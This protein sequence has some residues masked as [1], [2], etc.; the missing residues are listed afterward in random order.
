MLKIDTVFTPS[1]DWDLE[2]C[3]SRT[4]KWTRC[5]HEIAS[6]STLVWKPTT[7]SDLMSED[8]V[9]VCG[10]CF[11]DYIVMCG[12]EATSYGSSWSDI[13]HDK[14]DNLGTESDDATER[15]SEFTVCAR[16]F[17]VWTGD[18]PILEESLGITSYSES[19]FRRL[20]SRSTDP[21]KN[22]IDITGAI[23]Y[24]YGRIYL[25]HDIGICRDLHSVYYRYDHT[26]IHL[27]SE[28]DSDEWTDKVYESDDSPYDFC[29]PIPDRSDD[30]TDYRNTEDERDN[31]PDNIEYH[32]HDLAD[33]TRDPLSYGD[34][35]D[36]YH[37]HDDPGEPA[38]E[39]IETE[40]PPITR[41]LPTALFLSVFPF[42][43][44]LF[45]LLFDP[46]LDFSTYATHMKKRLRK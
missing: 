3:E 8:W 5:E 40:R 24:F 28:A 30:P 6:I 32:I 31:I 38:E 43:D 7:M 13:L 46:F 12:P 17:E 44:R 4:C 27:L 23:E 42:L 18:E 16:E 41:F 11:Y 33:S 25:S 19:C 15:I 45:D 29:D 20:Y 1:H 22:H 26:E 10:I 34:Y 21:G 35:D 36:S 37:L 2:I 9:L 39:L 14:C